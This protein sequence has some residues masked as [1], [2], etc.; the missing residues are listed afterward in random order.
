MSNTQIPKRPVLRYFGSKWRLARWL[1]DHFPPASSYDIFVDVY[2]GSGAII[3]QA[4]MVAGMIYNDLDGDVVNFFDVLRSEPD[5]LIEAISLTPYS[6]QEYKRAWQP[7]DDLEPLERA[8]RYYVRSWQSYGGTRPASPTGWS[9]QRKKSVTRSSLKLWT[10]HEGLRTVV[11]RL[12]KIQIECDT[13][14]SVIARYDTPRTLFY[15]DPPYVPKSRSDRQSL[16]AY[17]HEMDSA[18][19]AELLQT[20]TTIKGMAIISGYETVLYESMLT[21]WD[22]KSTLSRTTNTQ[23][24]K[25]ETIWISPQTVLQPQL[26]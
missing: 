18:M 5:A 16:G 14:L 2:G 4:P 1:F 11:E 24:P 21:G 6:R 8:R 7:L 10:E 20:L 23:R 25:R 9:A 15:C 26:L 3:L 13:A 19:H 17:A 12:R 22:K